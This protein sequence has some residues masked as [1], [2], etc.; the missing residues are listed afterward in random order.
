[1][2]E[3][4]KKGSPPLSERLT[5]LVSMVSPCETAADIGCDHGYVPVYLILNGICEHCIAADIHEGP[6]KRA[7]QNARLFGVSDKTKIRVG[8]GLDPL[9]KGE[10]D[11]IIISGM[12]GELIL[13]ILKDGFDKACSADELILG[14]QSDVKKVREFLCEKGFRIEEEK[15]IEDG[16]KYYPLIKARYQKE[17]GVLTE[18]QALYGPVLIKK[19]D[20]TLRRYLIKRLELL[21]KI[22]EGISGSESE[23]AVIRRTELMK[24]REMIA[25]VL[26]GYER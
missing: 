8:S 24:E 1:M 12:G 26:N 9:K 25:E 22:S 7:E 5:A 6:A 11:C 15:L 2:T 16:D 23:R 3:G 13:S 17:A 14:P 18:I 19:K 20:P 10:A 4:K 21:E